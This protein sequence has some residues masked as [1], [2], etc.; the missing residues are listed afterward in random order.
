MPSSSNTAR[1][2]QAAWSR[3][4][5]ADREIF[6]PLA[7]EITEADIDRAEAINGRW[8]NQVHMRNAYQEQIAQAR[9]NWV[10][11]RQLQLQNE[12]DVAATK[13]VNRVAI[14]Q[15]SHERSEIKKLAS[16]TIKGNKTQALAAHYQNL[17]TG[18]Q[19]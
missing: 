10:K 17:I 15:S 1:K 13:Q 7:G 12:V 9:R 16:A 3:A 11:V 8:A 6:M 14:A 4:F 5:G 18:G 19:S 2:I